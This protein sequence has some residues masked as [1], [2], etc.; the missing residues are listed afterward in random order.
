MAHTFHIERRDGPLISLSEWCTAVGV[1]PAMRMF[2]RRRHEIVNPSSGKKIL[3][4]A[5]KGDAELFFDGEWHSVFRWREGAGEFSPRFITREPS[6]PI[7]MAA[8]ELT[9]FLGAE[10]VGDEGEVYDLRSGRVKADELA[11]RSYT[12]AMINPS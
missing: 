2:T 1:T 5:K 9:N 8:A 6:H 10:I 11:L 12:S 3:W 7:W 4:A